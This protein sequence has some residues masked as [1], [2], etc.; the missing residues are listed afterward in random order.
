MAKTDYYLEAI[1]TAFDIAGHYD[2]MSQIP[3]EDKL[4]IAKSIANACENIEMP[5]CGSTGTMYDNEALK[6]RIKE[7]EAE[8]A[9]MEKNFKK[10]VARRRNVPVDDVRIGR[11]GDAY[12]Q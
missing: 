12:Y 5:G 10:N 9:Q 6:K 3:Q 2:L 4:T 1:E 11:D 7:L 8:L